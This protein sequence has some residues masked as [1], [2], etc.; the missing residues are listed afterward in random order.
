MIEMNEKICVHRCVYELCLHVSNPCLHTHLILHIAAAVECPHD[1]AWDSVV[2]SCLDYDF[3]HA[4]CTTLA[5]WRGSARQARQEIVT[6]S[7]YPQNRLHVEWLRSYC[8]CHTLRQNR[9]LDFLAT[10]QAFAGCAAVAGRW[11]AC[12]MHGIR[13]IWVQIMDVGAMV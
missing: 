1:F 6:R 11:T 7:F 8:W 2:E 5:D 3:H 13:E 10:D 9:S 4:G 12:R